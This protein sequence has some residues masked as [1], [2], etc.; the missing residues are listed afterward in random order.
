MVSPKL[1]IGSVDQALSI[2]SVFVMYSWFKV[3][4][5]TAHMLHVFVLVL[6]RESRLM[7][8]TLKFNP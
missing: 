1:F 2:H 8:Y 4:T 6:A 3:P 7:Q 5:D